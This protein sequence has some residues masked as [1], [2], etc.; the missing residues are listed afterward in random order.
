M[1]S[2][3]SFKEVKWGSG[4]LRA[5]SASKWLL[6]SSEFNVGFEKWWVLPLMESRQHWAVRADGETRACRNSAGG[7]SPQKDLKGCS[8]PFPP[9]L[10]R[11]MISKICRNIKITD[12]GVHIV[13]F[14]TVTHIT[15]F[16]C[17][18]L[19]CWAHQLWCVCQW[20]W[21]VQSKLCSPGEA[22]RVPSWFALNRVKMRS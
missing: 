14:Q 10:H 7:N 9:Q 2:T 19:F 13:P 16:L 21:W 22:L 1:F 6:L 17:H 18:K 11:S 5:V 3:S 15:R 12:I 4:K 8:I 20:W